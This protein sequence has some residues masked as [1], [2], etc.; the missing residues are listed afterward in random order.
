MFAATPERRRTLK[1]RHVK[2]ENFRGVRSLSWRVKGDFNCLIGAGDACKSTIL[3]ALDYALSP[4]PYLSFGDSDFFDLNVEQ[5]IVIQVTLADWDERRPEIREFFQEKNFAQFK[6]GLGDGGPLS[7]PRSDDE[8]A[9]SISLRVDKSLEPRWSVVKGP[10]RGEDG[11]GKRISYRDRSVLGMSR[12]DVLSDYHFTWGRNSILTRLSGEARGD[13]SEIL[14]QLNREIRQIDIS[15]GIAEY[16]DV[17]E[18]VRKE[19][20]RAGVGLTGLSPKIDI[21][22]RQS[23]DAGVLSLHEGA[24]PISSKDSGSKKLIAVAMQ[25]KLQGGKN[26]SLI[27]EIETG[28]E[29][30]RI[31][32]LLRRLKDSEQQVFTTTHSPVVVRELDAANLYVCQC[33]NNGKVDIESL[34][35]V[36]GI[37]GSL[38]RNAEAFLGRKIVVC[39]GATEIG[40]LRAYD[41]YRFGKG[42]SSPVWSLAT[43]YFDSNGAGKI[44]S[45]CRQLVE[46]GYKTAVLC[47]NDDQN[48]IS[49]DTVTQLRETGIHVCQWEKDSSIEKQLFQDIPWED[50]P[51]L[52]SVIADAHDTLELDT[53]TDLVRK[54]PKVENLDLSDDPAGW[55]E[56]D[57]LRNVIGHLAVKGER[58]WIK[59]IDYAEEVFGFALRRLPDGTVLKERLDELWEWIQNE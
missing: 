35:T 2:I 11:N 38:R 3:T 20:S 10:D 44:E 52:L 59:R 29:P 56:S 1:I 46:L 13:L 34:D 42:D 22:R 40:C 58:K 49:E 39:E 36:S 32:G 28:L 53:I 41:T 14:S 9:V 50:V 15:D 43:S 21:P 48:Q 45:V 16:Q 7:E 4:R 23:M 8:A 26:I 19:S 24:V 57:V 37:Q 47:D 17:A 31:R 55:P 51:E 12:L 6:C 30:H 25:M 33:D 18:A 5:D 54:Y 27:D